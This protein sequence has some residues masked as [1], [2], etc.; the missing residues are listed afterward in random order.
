L[1]RLYF[2]M[3]AR[4]RA[5][6][7][8]IKRAIVVLWI[9]AVGA[10]VPGA[11]AV[12][13]WTTKAIGGPLQGSQAPGVAAAGALPKKI[14]DGDSTRPL[15]TPDPIQTTAAAGSSTVQLIYDAAA[16]FGV[17]GSYLVSIAECES[18][19]N[20]SARSTTPPPKPG[21]PPA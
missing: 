12:F 9:I 20:P 19:L 3:R 15:A 18:G 17:S 2:G 1:D 13:D 16:E 21:P 4:R 11:S 8:R 7:A 10:G 14:D 5:R 6:R